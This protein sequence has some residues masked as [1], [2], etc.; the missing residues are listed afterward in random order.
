MAYAASHSN[1]WTRTIA[2]RRG[3]AAERTVLTVADSRAGWAF[4]SVPAK[5]LIR[6]PHRLDPPATEGGTSNLCAPQG[7]RQI[8]LWRRGSH[9][10]VARAVSASRAGNS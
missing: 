3:R 1:P 8:S 10:F 4:A 6:I 5:K 2:A 7:E 9:A